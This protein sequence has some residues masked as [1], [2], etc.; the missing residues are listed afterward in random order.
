MEATFVYHLVKEGQSF[1]SATCT[2]RLIREVFG[3]NPDFRCAETK[4]VAIATGKFNAQS[5]MYQFLNSFQFSGVLAPMATDILMD[6][7]RDVNFLTLCSDSSN[8]GNFKVLPVVVRFFSH[9]TGSQ[10]RLI[11][12]FRLDDETGETLFTKLKCV[13]E[14]FDIRP[15]V[16]AFS[17]DNAKENVGGLT[18]GGNKN[19]FSR[20]QKEFNNQLIGIGCTAHLLHKS[21]EKACDTFQPFFDIEA[22]V[23][24]IYNYFKSSTTRNTRLQRLIEADDELKLLGYANT[25]FIAF[26]GCIDRIIKNFDVIKEF[27]DTGEDTP[28]ALSRFFGHQLSKLLLIFVRDQCAY[29]ESAIR[30]IEGTH[31]SG[32]EAAQT[33]NSFC[34]SIH[35]RMEEK[36]TSL[37]FQN[38]LTNIFEELPFTDTVLK[39]VGKRNV[40]EEIEVDLTFIDEMVERFQSKF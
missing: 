19:V 3:K 6:E 30:S 34:A 1:Q 35:E 29:F 31:V 8:R 12:V 26:H 2:S 18:R 24:N 38:E 4:A 10:A 22:T 21:I 28:A 20:L 32:Y 15:K 37:E 25:R 13:W 5:F 9:K 14:K 17:G 33:I 16:K 40:H 7:I 23:V 39:K 27:F 36:F 11:D